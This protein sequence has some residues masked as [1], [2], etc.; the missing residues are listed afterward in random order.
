MTAA[1]PHRRGR[2]APAVRDRAL[3]RNLIEREQ[4]RLDASTPK[5]SL[6]YRR[7]HEVL[8]GGVASSFQR[9][10]PWPFYLAR[11]EGAF[12]WDIDDRRMTDF[13]NGFGSMVQGHANASIAAA[14]RE[15]I[16]KGSHFAAPTEDAVVVAEELARRFGLPKWRYTNSGSESTMDAIRIARGFTG[17]DVVMKMVGSYHG[18]H[19]GVMVSTG[20]DRDVPDKRGNWPSVAY[21]AGVPAPVAE[22]TVA[23]P[24]NDPE[25]LERRVHELE[26]ESRPPACL[27]MEP[28]M[29]LGMILP[30]PGYLEAVREITRRHGIV[31]IFDE[32]KTGLAV[33]AGG[34]TE[35]YGVA[36]DLVTL[37]KALGGGLPS[38]AIGGSEEVMRVVEDGSVYQVG[39]YNGNALVVAAA[40]ASLF[41]V[42]TP[43]AYVH[44]EQLNQRMI[45]GC[46][47]VLEAHGMPGY[48]L[49]LGA[50]GCVTLSP[51]RIVDY[52]TLRANQEA[53]LLRLT[54]LYAIN[55]GVFIT[56]ARPE[57]WTLSVAHSDEDV[58]TYVGFL[59]R[60]V[61]DLEGQVVA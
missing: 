38:G 16:S 40:R 10:V 17:R 50:R 3:L 31:L 45:D 18:H 55:S 22:L 8:V 61:T 20:G 47:R 57:Q 24:F 7:A 13:H 60:L 41:E 46:H 5:S 19:D 29:M 27:I 23:V 2:R 6:M 28:A 56:P 11:G 44:L 37:A 52:A 15:Q 30:E 14:V 9:R 36:P 58:D 25:A 54:W 53:D 48:A 34:V 49:G 59:D 4:G 39:T 21:G 26:R 1:P 32:V 33:A 42:L 43:D 12:V 51:T 35:R